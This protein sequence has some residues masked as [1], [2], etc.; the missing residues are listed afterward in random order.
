MSTKLEA[1]EQDKF[2]VEK[3]EILSPYFVKS[4][5]RCI[6]KPSKNIQPQINEE[7]LSPIRLMK[8]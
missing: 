7:V 3:K 4:K 2:I 1:D 6:E 5:E 8:K